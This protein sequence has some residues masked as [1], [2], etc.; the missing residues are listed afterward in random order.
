MAVFKVETKNKVDIDKKPRVY[1]TCHLEDFEKYFKKVC[2]DIFKTHDCAIYYT[3]DMTEFIAEDEK[4]VDLGRNNLFVV[5]VTFK[6]LTMPNRAM[7]EDIP[8][9]LKEH[10]PVLPIM[11]EPG[12]DEFYSKPDKFGELQYLNPYSTDLTEISYEEKLKKYLESVLISDDLTKRV[13]AA[14]DAYIFLSYRKKDRKYANELMRLIHSNPECRDIAIWFDEFLTPGESFKENIEKILDD[15]KLFTLLVTPQL[16]EKVIDENGKERDNYVISTELPLARKKKEEKGTDIFAVEMEKTDREALSSINIEDYTNPQNA[17]FRARLLETISRMAITTNN[18]PEHN[19][20]IGLAYLDGIDVEVDRERA[21]ELITSAA[22]KHLF[23]AIKK[24]I[25]MYQK[26]EGVSYNIDEAIRWHRILVVEY[27]LQFHEEATEENAVLYLTAAQDSFNT[28]MESGNVD[29]VKNTLTDYCCATI[30]VLDHDT[31]TFDNKLEIYEFDQFFKSGLLAELKGD[32]SDALRT[33]YFALSSIEEYVKDYNTCESVLLLGECL[34]KIAKCFAKI[35]NYK[36]SI[37]Y[38]KKALKHYEKLAKNDSRF[39]RNILNCYIGLSLTLKAQ[40]DFDG[41]ADWI[42]KALSLMSSFED[43]SLGINVDVT[44][45][46]LHLHL[47]DAVKDTQKD[48]LAIKSYKKVK[49]IAET[50]LENHHSNQ[51]VLL[52]GRCYKR[53]GDIAVSNQAISEAKDW[54]QKAVSRVECFQ[55]LKLSL[56]DKREI[57]DLYGSFAKIVEKEDLNKS[58]DLW[59]KQLALL[60]NLVDNGIE[61]DMFYENLEKIAT[62]EMDLDKALDDNSTKNVVAFEDIQNLGVCYEDLGDN[63]KA[64]GVLK[65]AHEHYLSSV[66]CFDDLYKEQPSVFVLLELAFVH[67]K[68]GNIDMEMQQFSKAITN[69]KTSLSMFMKYISKHSKLDACG[70][71]IATCVDLCDALE[72]GESYNASEMVVFLEQ[73]FGFVQKMYDNE[74]D[75]NASHT[76]SLICYLIF[77]TIALIYYNQHIYKQAEQYIK[78]AIEL[79]EQNFFQYNSQTNKAQLRTTYELAV[80]I[81]QKRRK[82]FDIIKLNKKIKELK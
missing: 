37:V 40:K 21:V 4:Q 39:Y 49:Y 29:N 26:G 35:E 11:M 45:C 31:A 67:R 52:L 54:Y 62:G 7:D 70:S 46:I 25:Y 48:Y 23:E 38:Y 8:Y 33:F 81:A 30:D 2:D 43:K 58:H 77:Y 9:A 47:G 5:P 69:Y 75:A 65:E 10:I 20:L 82:F 78:K 73:C 22:E 51:V 18:T 80:K 3:E 19:F 13:R 34:L 14:F 76:K 6:L 42:Q 27:E 56:E 41:C 15:C 24:L 64:R 1:F 61:V 57:A 44:L 66:K 60:K 32:L 63:A 50:Y 71:F 36:E 17:D 28:A 53:L 59:L 12:I 55:Q 72:K 74:C 16:L 79:M 68:I